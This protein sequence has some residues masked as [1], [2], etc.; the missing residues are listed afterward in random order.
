M[1]I[2][3]TWILTA[4]TAWM[5]AAE[6]P[7]RPEMVPVPGTRVEIAVYEVTNADFAAVVNWALQ[8]GRVQLPSTGPLMLDEKPLL[9]L[10]SPNLSIRREG[11]R[12]VVTSRDGKP[13]E[14]HPVVE[15]TWHGAVAYCHWLSAYCGEHS[16]Y[17]LATGAWASSQEGGGYRLPYEAEWIAAAGVE[18]AYAV[19]HPEPSLQVINAFDASIS[20][21]ANPLHFSFKPFTSPV[22]WYRQLHGEH[23]LSAA[24]CCDM[25]GNVWEWCQ[26]EVVP[27]FRAARGGS[28]YTDLR[29]ARISSRNRDRP[30][31]SFSDLGF[32]VVRE[33]PSGKASTAAPT[34]LP[35]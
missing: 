5:A 15:V 6:S 23:A 34:P 13:M 18:R 16:G 24:G 2:S 17:D 30:D 7:V 35:E 27:G 33:L 11:E 1:R 19:A 4:A 25:S 22:G 3:I 26:D 20:L 31:F 12:L 10:G 32:R 9:L 21:F 29:Y 14:K 28:W 8:E